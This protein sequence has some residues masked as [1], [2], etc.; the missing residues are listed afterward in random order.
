LLLNVVK[1]PLTRRFL[2]SEVLMQK[3]RL[4]RQQQ[5]TGFEPAVRK[6]GKPNQPLN[7]KLDPFE[8]ANGFVSNGYSV[9]SS[10]FVKNHTD[11]QAERMN[12]LIH[13]ALQMTADIAAGKSLLTEDDAFMRIVTAHGCRISALAFGKARFTP[14]SW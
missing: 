3:G 8:P 6:E 2:T 4:S 10:R 7:K 5:P 1:K 12:D 13:Q 14:P 11:A 9:Y